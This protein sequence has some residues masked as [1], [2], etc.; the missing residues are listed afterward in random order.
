[1]RKALKAAALLALLAALT[2]SAAAA[3]SDQTIESHSF[4][5][6]TTSKKKYDLRARGGRV[7]LRVKAYVREGAVKLVVRDA[8]GRVRQDAH[9]T[10]SQS[11]PSTYN[12][13]SGEVTSAAGAWT[14]EVELTEAVGSYEFTWTTE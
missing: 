4:D 8:S 9:L 13:D 7:R 10:P 5:H 6:K 1:M 2:A 3:H 12:V 14:V 11:R